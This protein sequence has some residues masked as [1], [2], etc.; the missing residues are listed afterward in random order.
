MISAGR[1]FLGN[2]CVAHS[3]VS[4]SGMGAT[5]E[6][7]TGR[8]PVILCGLGAW[9]TETLRLCKK[10]R[11]VVTVW[12]PL[13]RVHGSKGTE[14]LCLECQASSLL[15]GSQLTRYFDFEI[16]LSVV[17]A[18]PKLIKGR[19]AQ[20]PL[21]PTLDVSPVRLT[22][23]SE[24]FLYGGSRKGFVVKADCYFPSI[25]D[26]LASPTAYKLV[27][28]ILFNQGTIVKTNGSSLIK[29]FN[30]RC[31]ESLAYRLGIHP[32][33]SASRSVL[34]NASPEAIQN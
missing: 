21:I 18:L 11:V 2:L 4:S 5:F 7:A 19:V 15:C 3:S 13:I 1:V 30:N 23:R 8:L 16:P 14:E 20:A 34:L 24:L 17:N 25:Q 27:A 28:Y 12:N 9:D 10:S 29:A 22:A 33:V 26:T 6:D 32:R 31:I